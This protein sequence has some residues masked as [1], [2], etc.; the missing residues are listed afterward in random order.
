MKNN[1]IIL[2]IGIGIGIIATRECSKKTYSEVEIPAKEGFLKSKDSIIYVPI[3]TP[4]EVPKWYKDVAK[5]KDL[6][7]TIEALKI[8]TAHYKAEFEFA[9]ADYQYSDS[10]AKAEK[11][12]NAIKPKQ[13]NQSYNDSLIRI[14]ALGVVNGE[15]RD[16]QL[17]YLIKEKKVKTPIKKSLYSFAG[18]VGTGA[19]LQP[20]YKVGVGYHNF[21]IDYTTN[22]NI[23]IGYRIKF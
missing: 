16:M 6:L 18:G 19:D 20:I 22:R 8:D 12:K 21:E 14:E 10:V 13:F 11:F 17:L 1:I 23:F 4:V 9:L 7:Q 3:E 5:E 15:I 2:I